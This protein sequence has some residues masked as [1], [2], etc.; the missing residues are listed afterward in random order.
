MLAD[1]QPCEGAG[2]DATPQ[3][4]SITPWVVK[5]RR[6]RLASMRSLVGLRVDALRAA[7]TRSKKLISEA[8]SQIRL[9][10]AIYARKRSG[11]TFVAVTGSSGKTT[12]AALI[13]IFYPVWLRFARSSGPT[14]IEPKCD[15]C[16]IPR[17]M[18]ISSARRVLAA[19]GRSSP[20]WMSSDRLSA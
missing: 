7:R 17:R 16:S 1:H 3:Y 14:S 2:S 19:P 18:V 4:L 5:R 15:R 8:D 12:T 9:W 11:A 13:A 20:C 10:R 6:L